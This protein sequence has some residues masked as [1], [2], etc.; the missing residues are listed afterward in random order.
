MR[1]GFVSGDL[2]RG[3]ANAGSVVTRKVVM[4]KPGDEEKFWK[5]V[6]AK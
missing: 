5:S 4:V 1:V 6:S 2:R 3:G